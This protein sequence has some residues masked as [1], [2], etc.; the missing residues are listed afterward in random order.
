MDDRV[1]SRSWRSS[2]LQK[3]ASDLSSESPPPP[4]LEPSGPLSLINGMCLVGGKLEN[5]RLRPWDT[6]LTLT[7]TIG[8]SPVR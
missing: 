3:D 1:S 6:A 7:N 4:G 2:D 5:G 8:S